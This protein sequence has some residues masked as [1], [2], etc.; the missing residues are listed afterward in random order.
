MQVR[1]KYQLSL[2]Q[3][4]GPLDGMDQIHLKRHSITGIICVEKHIPSDL[5]PIYTYLKEHPG[6]YIPAIYECIA[7]GDQLLIIEEYIQGR[8]LEARIQE[9]LISESET[10]RIMMELCE[11]LQTL[12]NATPPIICRDLKAENIM[13][14]QNGNVKII[15]F[16]IARTYQDGKKRD[17]K[18]MGT[19]EY[20]APEQFG[21]FQTDNRTDIYALGILANYMVTGK[22]PV[23]QMISGA[24]SDIVKKCT[25]LDPK[26][27][28]QSV[29]ELMSDL[30]AHFPALPQ[31]SEKTPVTHSFVPPGFR[32]HTP[33]KMILSVIGYLLITDI[34][35]SVEM[36]SNGRPVTGTLL[37][38][39]QGVIWISQLILVGLIFNYRGFRH[40]FPLVR[41]DRPGV[42]ILGYI[43]A[44]FLLLFLA[45]AICAVF[46][47]SPL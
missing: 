22:F 47:L 3:D 16:N 5:S 27:R 28:Y 21:F 38:L 39:E 25:C 6:P 26:E 44:E 18:L 46:D 13:I 17:T 20:A 29:E 1:E 31:T 32:S 19:A 24:L 41:S 40:R 12:H 11:A 36:T 15:D 33:W 8:T 43:I 10:V 45:A 7:A 4:L 34:A 35:F 42:R 23:E 14:D 9:Q 37:R 30:Q 2:Y